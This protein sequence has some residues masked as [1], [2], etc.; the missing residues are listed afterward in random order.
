MVLSFKGQ[1]LVNGDA[2]SALTLQRAVTRVGLLQRR[3]N[4]VK[5]LRNRPEGLDRRQW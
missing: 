3:F 1:L 2:W 4:L 5:A